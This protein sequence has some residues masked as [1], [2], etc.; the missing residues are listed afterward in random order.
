[1]IT[2]CR[3]DTFDHFKDDALI[4]G[5]TT[6]QAGIHLHGVVIA[7]HD[8]LT[9]RGSLRRWRHQGHFRIGRRLRRM[10]HFDGGQG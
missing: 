2:G 3:L 9:V 10:F 1:M 5:G 8:A 6:G 4:Y 7:A